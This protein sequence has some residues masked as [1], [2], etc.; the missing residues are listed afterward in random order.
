MTK[1]IEN[2]KEQ[3]AKIVTAKLSQLTL[4]PLNPRQKADPEKLLALAISIKTVGL[5][6]NLIGIQQNGTIEIVAGG[7]RLQAMKHLVSNDDMKETDTILVK[8]ADNEEDAIKWAAAENE[9]RENLTP[10]QEVRSYRA[11]GD[12]GLSVKEIANANAKTVKH[13]QGRL[14]LADLPDVILNALDGGD[15]T[16]DTASAYTVSDNPE[17]Q[18]EVFEANKD[19]YW[20]RDN[21]QFIKRQLLE[22]A[23]GGSDMRAKFVTRETYEEAGGAITEDLFSEDIYFDDSDLLN[24]LAEDKM[25]VLE[26]DLIKQGWKWA[27]GF[28]ATRNYELIYN[29]E[30]VQPISPELTE[31]NQTRLEMLEQRA[32]DEEASEQELAEYADLEKLAAPFFTDEQRKVSGVII[33]LSARGEVDLHMGNDRQ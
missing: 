5:L 23:I 21:A 18:T 15:I 19:N 7:R 12:A 1:K 6:Q 24:K 22:Q 9:A 17:K 4:S 33:Y 26:A 11:M 29:M 16:L 28:V 8:L 31:Q 30:S 20:N 27:N 3:N 14:K 2:T 13:V 25:K 32:N 10:A